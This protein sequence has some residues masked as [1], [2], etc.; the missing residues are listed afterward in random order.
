MRN[1]RFV[2]AAVVALTLSGCANDPGPAATIGSV[3]STSAIAAA[4][5]SL[6]KVPAGVVAAAEAWALSTCGWG[7]GLISAG[8]ADRTEAIC[9][10][11]EVHPLEGPRTATTLFVLITA[12]RAVT[13]ADGSVTTSRFVEPREMAASD[14]Q[15]HVGG[16][17]EG[18]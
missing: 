11:V 12:E 7:P 10:D 4:T 6:Q 16:R 13:G 2:G 15:W 3:A 17:V 9:V 5:S 18:G 8:H 14:G 1:I